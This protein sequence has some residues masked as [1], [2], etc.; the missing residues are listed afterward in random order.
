MSSTRSMPLPSALGG[1]ASGGS[2]GQSNLLGPS[3]RPRP[4]LQTLVRW[5]PWVVLP[6]SAFEGQ[7]VPPR[8]V[9]VGLGAVVALTECL[10]VADDRG[11]ALGPRVDVVDLLGR[12]AASSP[13]KQQRALAAVAGKGHHDSACLELEAPPRIAPLEARSPARERERQDDDEQDDRDEDRQERLDAVKDPAEKR[14]EVDPGRRILNSHTETL[15]VVSDVSVIHKPSDG[16][17]SR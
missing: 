6:A 16:P 3:C 1:G 12:L 8:W 5:R 9:P 14:A 11:A 7:D 13:C 2:C 15:S 17:L 10:A 4:S